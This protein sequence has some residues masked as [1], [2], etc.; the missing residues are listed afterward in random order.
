MGMLKESKHSNP[1][2]TFEHSA[3]S[4]AV[5]HTRQSRRQ[6]RIP[7]HGQENS[8]TT[9]SARDTGPSKQTPMISGLSSDHH[10]PTSTM[11]QDGRKK[12]N[13]CELCMSLI[14]LAHNPDDATS[15]RI[16]LMVIKWIRHLPTFASLSMHDQVFVDSKRTSMSTD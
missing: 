2:L 8:E 9:V 11:K 15:R 7:W 1:V 16:L 14:Y 10:R 12:L 13:Q 3:S 6:N 5:Q 4:L